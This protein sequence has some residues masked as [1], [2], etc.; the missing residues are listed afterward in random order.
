MMRVG[1]ILRDYAE[2]GAV[3]AQIALWG[4][5]DDQT[6][7]TKSGHV[8][9]VYRIH[10][11]DAEGLTHDQ[12]RQLVHQVEAALRLLDERCRVYQYVLKQEAEP[13]VA[14]RCARPV[15]QEAITRRVEFLNA[16]RAHLF[17]LDHFLVLMYEPAATASTHVFA[18]A[19]R[20]PQEALRAW[21][22]PSHRYRL[23]ETELERAID[24]LHHKAKGFEVQLA[25]IGVERLDKRQAFAFFRRLVNYDAARAS[26]ASLTY[27]THLDYFVADSPIEC[28][29]DHLIVGRH[30]VKVLTMKEPPTQTFAHMLADVMALPGHVVAC[31]EW[32]RLPADQAR[33][34]IHS[35]RRHFFNKRVSLI[36]YVSSDTRPEEMLVDD[37]ASATVRQLGDALTETEVNGHFFGLASLTLVL[38]GT[39]TRQLQA[40]AAEATKVLAAHDGSAF[41]ESYNLLNAWLATI[42][43]NG[44]CNLRRL[45]LLETNLADLSFVFTLDRGEP[46]SR[47]LQGPALVA[48]ETPA[49]VPYWFNLHVDDVGHTLVLGATGSGKSFL[50]NVVITHL[51]Q[52][53]PL[54]VV[55]DLGHSYRKLAGLLDGGYLELGLGQ[56][57]VTM[58]PFDLSEPTPEALHFLHAFTRVLLEGEDGYRLSDA[59]D[60]ETYD[61]VENLFVLDP[62][63]RR[64][65]TLANLLPRALGARLHKWVEGGRYGA[66]FDNPR[67]T[68]TIDRLQVFDFEAM[69]EYPSL[70]EPLLFYVL[71]RVDRRV[72]DAAEA[73]HLKVCVMDEAWRLIQHPALRSYVQEALKTWRKRNAAILL[74]TQAIDDFASTD[75][76]RTVVESCPTRL[77]LANPSMDRRQYTELFQMNEMELEL[78][79][80]LAPRQ[81]VLLKRPNLAKVLTLRVDPKSYWIY[82]NTPVDNERVAAVLRDVGLAEGIDRLAA[83]A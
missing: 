22:A 39:D 61:A 75:L 14:A 35:R 60:R 59:E 77:L 69:R 26:A 38:A 13:F 43:G 6:F 80:G 12:R 31:L 23:V 37:S 73:G 83:S 3:N 54:T 72:H 24:T 34:D 67:D 55:L 41:E 63:Q 52:Y 44:A 15:A 79:S 71:H 81:Q 46:T 30:A 70:L 45:S 64:L 5:V 40:T 21:L 8:G 48:F 49:N 28:H 32:Q 36:N 47:Y 11:R 51:Q 53:D 19:W 1:R 65:F 2:A 7:L 76:L 58:N 56:Q 82:T 29:R 20:Q 68:L 16:R 78:L 25:D 4:F 62:A 10:G 33:R 17:T 27:D 74:A 66:L 42:P 50:L 57:G 18:R 9:L